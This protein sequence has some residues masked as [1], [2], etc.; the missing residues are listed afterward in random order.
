V[1]EL[2]WLAEAEN[3][4][5]VPVIDV[6]PVTLTMTSATGNPLAALNAMSYGDDDGAE[7]ETIA[8][9]IARACPVPLRF[10]ID[11]TFDDGALFRPTQMEDK[12]AL[13][14]RR[15]RLLF[16][17]SWMRAL[18]V[19]TPFRIED[20]Y[21]TVTGLEG[22]FAEEEP[23]ELTAAIADFIIRSHGLGIVH[24]PHCQ[25]IPDRTSTKPRCSASR[26][27]D[28][29]PSSPLIIAGRHLNLTSRSGRST[30]PTRNL[31]RSRLR[32]VVGVF[33]SGIRRSGALALACSPCEMP[34]SAPANLQD[35]L[36][37][38]RRRVQGYLTC[39]QPSGLHQPA[40]T[41]AFA[42]ARRSVAATPN[43]LE[44]A[45]PVGLWPRASGVPSTQ[46]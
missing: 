45:T 8:L 42:S 3:P 23:V 25:L 34:R 43:L 46:R 11:A 26:C 2:Q 4:W 30:V 44:N 1:A 27:T 38:A 9:P 33:A 37:S 6:R 19:A 15:Q 20:D 35:Q 32:L 5:S 13:F 39:T 22:S 29:K 16:V 10:R 7:F 31:A 24:P 18:I 12:W 14:V 41:M 28:D 40:S 21:L 17:R 36:C